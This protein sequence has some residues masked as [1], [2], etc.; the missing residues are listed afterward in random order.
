M[1]DAIKAQQCCLLNILINIWITMKIAI[2]VLVLAAVSAFAADQT[3]EEAE[4]EAFVQHLM[5]G[6]N[7]E[8]DNVEKFIEKLVNEEEETAS[9]QDETASEQD[10]LD[11]RDIDAMLVQMQEDDGDDDIATLQELIAR[12]QDPDV[13]AQWGRRRRRRRKIIRRVIRKVSR[14]VTK[15]VNNL[16]VKKILP[17]KCYKGWVKDELNCEHKWKII[18]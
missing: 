13:T 6:H 18:V 8:G 15:F 1:H 7:V 14:G 2:L 16:I 11:N 9:E 17:Y 4:I 3:N 12:E 5:K 10:E